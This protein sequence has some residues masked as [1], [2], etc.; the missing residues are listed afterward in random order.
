MKTLQTMM[1]IRNSMIPRITPA[2]VATMRVVL[3]DSSSVGVRV[4]VVGVGPD[5]GG[6]GV[7]EEEGRGRGRVSE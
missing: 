1:V 2:I 4:C 7:T 5:G 6:G 3:E